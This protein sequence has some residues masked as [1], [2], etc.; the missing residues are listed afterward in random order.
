MATCGSLCGTHIMF[1]AQATPSR[2]NE[3]VESHCEATPFLRRI[4][5][6]TASVAGRIPTMKKGLFGTYTCRKVSECE[7]RR[8]ELT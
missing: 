2:I 8:L 7:C 1:A 4:E 3:L 6:A 5:V